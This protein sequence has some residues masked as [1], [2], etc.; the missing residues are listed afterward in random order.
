MFLSFKFYRNGLFLEKDHCRAMFYIYIILLIPKFFFASY[1]TKLASLLFVT[2]FLAL[3]KILYFILLFLREMCYLDLTMYVSFFE[4]AF[5]LEKGASIIFSISFLILQAKLKTAGG[6]VPST[7][8]S[9]SSPPTLSRSSPPPSP[10]PPTPTRLQ[11]P[12]TRRKRRGN[13]RTEISCS[14]EWRTRGL[15]GPTS[16]SP[17]RPSTRP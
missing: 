10:Q 8:S 1:P 17:C 5:F 7:A 13:T 14:R 6:A 4:S 3:K 12:R 2:F 15:S 9:A 11:Q 16:R